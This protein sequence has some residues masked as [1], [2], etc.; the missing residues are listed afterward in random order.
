M[1]VAY[2]R[3]TSV[4]C[5]DNGKVVDADV[6]KYVEGQYLT[7]SLNTVKVTLQYNSRFKE[8]IGS[9]GGLEFKSSGPKVLGK[10]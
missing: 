2:D 4:T 9:M 5:I 6:I 3:V 8:Y 1:R 7:V 10:Y